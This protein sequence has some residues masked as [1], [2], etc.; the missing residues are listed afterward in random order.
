MPKHLLFTV[1][2]LIS[3]SCFAQYMSISGSVQDTVTKKPLPNSVAMLVRLKDSVLVNFTRSNEKGDFVFSDVKID[4]LELI[5]SN[6][7][8]GDQ[9]FYIV[10]SQVNKTFNLGTII[11]PPK[12]KD[13][14]EVIIYAFKDPVYYKGDTLVYSVD[15]FK[16]KPNA[17]VEDLLKKLP[18]IKVDQSG[19]ITS[20]GKAVDQ[21]LVD[22]DEFFGTDPTVATRNLG[23]N[24]VESVQVYE[25]KDENSTNGENLQIMNLKLKD[26]AKKGYFGKA[27]AA[28]DFQK[29][30]EGEVFANKFK[31]SQ[32]ISVFGLM[33]NTPKTSVG[34]GDIYKYGL[35]NEGP[36][37][38]EN[39]M[40]PYI[41]DPA[42]IP[43]SIKSGIYYNDKLGKKTKLNLNYTYGSKK[44]DARST[45]RSQYFLSDSS[46]TTNAESHDIQNNESHA[47]N[48]K[49]IQTLDSL[50]ELEF[51][52]KL[53]LNKNTTSNET[54]TSFFTNKDSLT[55]QAAVSN[56]SDIG[57]YD[58][59]TF[60]RLTRKFKK[61]DRKFRMNYNYILNGSQS[62][63]ILKSLNTGTD[64]LKDINQKKDNDA[65]NQTH[66][67]LVSYT[68][69]ITKKIKLQV[70]YNVNYN[71]SKQSKITKDFQNGDYSLTNPL[72]T[73][74]FE[75]KR[76]FQSV[77]GM[78]MYETKKQGL[79]TGARARSISFIN[80]NL[81]NNDKFK[82]SVNTILPYLYYHWNI[83]QGA[84]FNFRYMT[85]SNQPTINQLQP[86]P[87]NTNPIQ[88]KV[89]N[90]DLRP[91]Y[92]HNFEINYNIFKPLSGRY[93]GG[94]IVFMAVNNDFTNAITY[95]QLGRTLTQTV[96]V[97]GNYNSNFNLWAGIPFKDKMFSLDPNAN[98]SYQKNTNFINGEKNSTKTASISAGLGASFNIDTLNFRLNYNYSYNVPSS[99]LNT[100]SIK[101]YTYQEYGAYLYLKLPFKFSIET[102]AKYIIN[103]NRA[104]GYNINYV[105]W[106]ASLSKTFLKT[107]NLILSIIGND[108]LNKNISNE[109]TIVDNV[110]TDTKTNIIT[111]YFLLQLVYKF[112]NNK[113]KYNDDF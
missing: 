17:T 99:S 103:S 55:H 39:G 98:G 101:P 76:T 84:R 109:R 8:F 105:L 20:Q 53:K 96:N 50:T 25:K 85:L 78:F 29:F 37:F 62:D 70:E 67:A 68:E 73:N 34:Y 33:A 16:V 42:G 52:P 58:L 24:T 22:G 41:Q 5:I 77:G 2:L 79:Y 60:I 9:S 38:D 30:Y 32:K 6:P 61:K 28:S 100:T 1:C 3:S 65:N 35:N 71:L 27:S 80:T 82:Y 45:A 19:K 54:I 106:N 49:L 93:I 83:G 4:T 95:D 15:S 72:F 43:K 90:P 51:E 57:G 113:T 11:L 108:L 40:S 47:I 81:I 59:N 48:M 44:L 14:K 91:T 107:E 75:N 88:V 74:N 18:G 110:I 12:N 46:Y 69:P 26:D 31:G 56:S 63:G 7:L 64:T 94:N 86:V 10:G 112:N 92:T 13:L 104:P 36:T 21:V 97:N 111:R 89:G 23:A 102:D 66:N 87:D